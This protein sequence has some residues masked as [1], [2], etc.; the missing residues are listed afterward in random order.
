MLSCTLLTRLAK[1]FDLFKAE[2]RD[3]LQKFKQ[4]LRFLFLRVLGLCQVGNQPT[5]LIK[6]MSIFVQ[7]GFWS[8]IP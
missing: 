2:H 5:Y 3:R 1:T 6:F 8:A 4:L 7:W